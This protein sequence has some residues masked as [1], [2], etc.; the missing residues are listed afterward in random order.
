[1]VVVEAWEASG[2]MPNAGAECRGGVVIWS[3]SH[4]RRWSGVG[5]Q[6]ASS[7]GLQLWLWAGV[8]WKE[9]G[10][11]LRRQSCWAGNPRRSNACRGPP[12]ALDDSGG[13][14]EHPRWS[15][16]HF[17]APPALEA[18]PG[19]PRWV[20]LA[21]RQHPPAPLACSEPEAQ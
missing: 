4:A 11:A 18:L 17:P 13:S 19:A 1:M 14:F 7:V 6:V 3:V 15:A 2:R 12:Q 8:L 21:Q 16:S 10:S 9:A 5:V 20:I